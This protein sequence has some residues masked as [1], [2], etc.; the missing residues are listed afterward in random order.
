MLIVLPVIVVYY[1]FLMQLQESLVSSYLLLLFWALVLTGITLIASFRAR[2]DVIGRLTWRA[3]EYTEVMFAWIRTGVLP[4]GRPSS[5]VAF[6]AKQTMLYC[7]LALLSANLLSL[8]LGCALLNYMNCYV[9]ALAQSSSSKG[10]AILMG[11]NP[12]SLIRVCAFLWLGIVC[13]LP[14]LSRVDLPVP[15]FSYTM[16]LPG[17]AGVIAD[18]ALK[19]VLSRSWSRRLRTLV[20]LQE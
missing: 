10:R 17:L 6:H 20:I 4:E 19:I 12:W 2:T 9:A 13:S 18:M 11:W 14:L 16:V 8:L 3:R 15:D 7:V 1:P 5:V